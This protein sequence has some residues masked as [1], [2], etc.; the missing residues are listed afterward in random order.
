MVSALTVMAF[1]AGGSFSIF[2]LDQILLAVGNTFPGSPANCHGA[3]G[4]VAAVASTIFHMP[5]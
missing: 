4:M 3:C 2:K 1:H 5:K